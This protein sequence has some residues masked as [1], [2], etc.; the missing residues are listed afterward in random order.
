[1]LG[2]EP[3][4]VIEAACGHYAGVR[5][6]PIIGVIDAREFSIAPDE[7]TALVMG[8]VEGETGIRP[9]PLRW[10]GEAWEPHPDLQGGLNASLKGARIAPHE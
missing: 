3:V 5:P 9:I 10:N 4:P 8:T 2:L 6:V 7:Q 1:M